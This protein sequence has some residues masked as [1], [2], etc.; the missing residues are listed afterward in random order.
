[1]DKKEDDKI[2][3]CILFLIRWTL[4]NAAVILNANFQTDIKQISGAFHVNL[5]SGEYHKT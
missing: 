4:T 2:M 1:M 5:S 3:K